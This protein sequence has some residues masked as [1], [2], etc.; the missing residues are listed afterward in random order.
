M[1]RALSEENKRL[2][3][4]IK[5]SDGDTAGVA[6]TIGVSRTAISSR[7]NNKTNGAW[8]SA[9]KRERSRRRA[10]ERK[11]SARVRRALRDAQHEGVPGIRRVEFRVRRNLARIAML[12][13]VPLDRLRARVEVAVPGVFDMLM[14][15]DDL[16]A[17]GQ[18]ETVA[19]MLMLVASVL[20]IELGASELL[21]RIS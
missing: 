14:D 9:F 1:S 7:L 17:A 5:A 6:C 15:E 16:W 13:D 20:G 19:D 10:R 18:A 11:R 12:R 4:L 3:R 2:R 8:W 21:R